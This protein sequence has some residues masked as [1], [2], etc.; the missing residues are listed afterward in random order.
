MTLSDTLG[1]T[2]TGAS[3]VWAPI[4]CRTT[5]SAPTATVGRFLEVSVASDE[6]AGYLGRGCL[7]RGH[8]RLSHSG[9]LVWQGSLCSHGALLLS[10]T[11]TQLA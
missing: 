6:V 7:F 1:A 9:Y 3:V 8:E 10:V 4:R 5:F 2:F 11:P